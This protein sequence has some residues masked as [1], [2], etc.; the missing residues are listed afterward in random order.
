M[1]R[2]S[3]D[4]SVSRADPATVDALQPSAEQDEPDRHG[5]RRLLT[6]R[7]REQRR[8][9]QHLPHE[10]RRHTAQTVGE[11]A[12]H[13]RERVHAGDVQAEGE[14][15]DREIGPVVQ[16][17][18][19]RHRHDRDHDPVRGGDGED[20]VPRDDGPIRLRDARGR[21]G[22]G[23]PLGHDPLGEQQRIGTQRDEVERDREQLGDDRE[24][25]RAGQR[26]HPDRIADE[27]SRP[28]EIRTEDGADGRRPDDDREVAT[29][30]RVGRE[31]GRGEARLQVRGLTRRRSSRNAGE[32]ERERPH[33]RS[34][35]RRR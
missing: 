35:R 29:A 7:R 11:D 31:V 16:Q 10:D 6:E 25:V 4:A 9:E 3:D 34:R 15:D 19:R 17:V 1:R 5:G 13:G 21:A 2:A 23:A 32:E 8:H 24:Q 26:R 30:R 14:P 20:G 27:L 22:I 33:R 28:R 18:H 12:E